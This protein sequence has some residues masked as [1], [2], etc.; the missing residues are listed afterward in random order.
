MVRG[1]CWRDRVRTSCCSCC[2]LSAFKTLLHDISHGRG[3][4]CGV[5][6]IELCLTRLLSVL[7]WSSGSAGADLMVVEAV[8]GF[9]SW[10]L[11][12]PGE[13]CWLLGVS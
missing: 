10:L 8:S 13:V 2:T 6:G 3:E 11:G 5:D 9:S 7:Q 1:V 4:V 12:L